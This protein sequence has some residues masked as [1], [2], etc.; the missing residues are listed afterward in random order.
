MSALRWES[1]YFETEGPEHTDE[2]LQIVKEASDRLGVRDVVVASTR[3][4]TGVRA[5]E[6]LLPGR[7]LVIVTHMAGFKSP[8]T[9]EL[10]PDSRRRMEELGAKVLVA[11]HALSGVERAMRKQLGTYGPVELMANALRLFGE[12][13]KVC[14]EIAVMAADA[15]LIPVDRDVI[16]VAGTGKGADTAA[17][18]R[19]AHSSNFFD[20]RVKVILCKPL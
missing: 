12:G 11:T 20:L 9:L 17:V 19:P 15:G 3:G 13:I 8:G 2:V 7:N 4:Y 10:D 6:T 14:V 18:V 5:A 1:T 16:C